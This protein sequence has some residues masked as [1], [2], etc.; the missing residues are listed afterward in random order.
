MQPTRRPRGVDRSRYL[1]VINFE[2]IIWTLGSV[3]PDFSARELYLLQ[4][5]GYTQ[6]LSHYVMGEQESDTL[7]DIIS[8]NEGNLGFIANR[9]GFNVSP[10]DGSNAI[11]AT[12]PNLKRYP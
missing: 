12:S 4:Y 5:G 2:N 6:V 10:L 1:L 7:K 11:R 3:N 9:V 8:G